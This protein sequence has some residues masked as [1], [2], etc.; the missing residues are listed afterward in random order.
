MLHGCSVRPLAPRA[1]VLYSNS[2]RETTDD[3]YIGCVFVMRTR[4]AFVCLL[5]CLLTVFLVATAKT[6]S[7]RQRSRAHA[8]YTDIWLVVEAMAMVV[9]VLC[10]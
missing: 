9:V 8:K 1:Q 10:R 3:I 6:T 5:A 4:T 7:R 2:Q